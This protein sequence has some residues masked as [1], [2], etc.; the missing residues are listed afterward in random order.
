MKI[1][2]VFARLISP[3]FEE[4]NF[5][6][7]VSGSGDSGTVTFVS[8]DHCIQHWKITPEQPVGRRL[9]VPGVCKFDDRRAARKVSSHGLP[10]RQK[11]RSNR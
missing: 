7:H 6:T 9:D 8:L 2:L 5:K 4:R 3:G 11:F 10:G 1:L